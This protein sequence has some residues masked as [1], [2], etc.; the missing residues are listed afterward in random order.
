MLAASI[1]EII[2]SCNKRNNMNEKDMGTL[3]GFNDNAFLF[4]ENINLGKIDKIKNKCITQLLPGGGT[5]FLNAFKEASKILNNI[6]GNDYSHKSIILL[7][8]GLNK[9]LDETLI[10]IKNDV[11]IVFN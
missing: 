8:D 10:Y 2:N 3:I 11:S 9:T 5:S 6:N 7:T 1:E 4:F